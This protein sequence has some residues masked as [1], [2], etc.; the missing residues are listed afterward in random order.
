MRKWTLLF[1][2]AGLAVPVFAVGQVTVGVACF[3][4]TLSELVTGA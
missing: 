2:A 1:L 3:T 4:S